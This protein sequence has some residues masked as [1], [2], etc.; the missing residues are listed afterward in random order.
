MGTVFGTWRL[1][2]PRRSPWRRSHD[3]R[4][5]WAGWQ[6]GGPGVLASGVQQRGPGARGPAAGVWRAGGAWRAM[7]RLGTAMPRQVEGCVILWARHVASHEAVSWQPPSGRL[8]G[9][10][11]RRGHGSIHRD[12]AAPGPY[13]V[14]V[15]V[16]P[17]SP[18]IPRA[19][20][21]AGEAGLSSIQRRHMSLPYLPLPDLPLCL[22]RAVRT[23]GWTR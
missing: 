6:L 19:R 23:V 12:Y 7:H 3:E 4:I 16:Q 10:W 15:S 11:M 5:D 21:R 22:C 13:I 17:A 8:M 14:V 18:W 1:P 20:P 2:S 9:R